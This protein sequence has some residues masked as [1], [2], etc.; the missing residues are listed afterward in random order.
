[1]GHRVWLT[2]PTFSEAENLERMVRAVLPALERAAPGDH[3]VLVVDDASPDGTGAIA[4]RLAE[5]LPAVEVLHRARKEG[6]GRAYLAGFEHALAGGAQL[7]AVMDCDFSH[8]PSSLPALIAAAEGSD[9]VIGSR[10]VRGGQIPEWPWLRRLLSRAGSVYAR[11][12]LGVQVRDLTGGFKCIRREVLEAIEPRSL[13]SQ[14]YVFNI[15]LTYRALLAGFRV[16]EV[17]IVFRDRRAGASKM[18]LPIAFEALWLVPRLRRSARDVRGV[19]EG[20][21]APDVDASA[22]EEASLAPA[23]SERV[24]G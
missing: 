16:R 7:V 14:G 8:E 3:R 11:R 20:L 18:S 6:L 23:A 4:D 19:R 21:A 13:R 5:E 2:L 24:G 22:P 10:Y 1:M 9:L 15:E 17:P 12:L